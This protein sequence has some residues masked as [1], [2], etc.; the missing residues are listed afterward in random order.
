MQSKVPKFRL[1]VVDQKNEMNIVSK[2]VRSFGIFEE[3]EILNNNNFESQ[4]D[5][6]NSSFDLHFVHHPPNPFPSTVS[7]LISSLAQASGGVDP[8]TLRC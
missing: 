2:F 3:D 5:L 8:T 7:T 6:C 1:P 4:D